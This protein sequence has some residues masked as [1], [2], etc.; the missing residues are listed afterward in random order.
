MVLPL[1]KLPA[2]GPPPRCKLLILLNFLRGRVHIRAGKQP[3][4][5][6][7]AGQLPTT[8]TYPAPPR[9][10]R[11]ATPSRS[12]DG[13]VTGAGYVRN[14][15]KKEKAEAMCSVVSSTWR[16]EGKP[17]CLGWHTSEKGAMFSVRH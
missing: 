6:T 17:Q 15:A 1:A 9:S 7:P 4:S 11:T 13:L 14:P 10:H 2:T 12:D 3:K 8:P 16:T 5:I